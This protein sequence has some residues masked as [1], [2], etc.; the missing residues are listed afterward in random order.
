MDARAR[1]ERD[2]DL[3]AF[4][5]L[6]T[7]DF[8]LIN[9]RGELLDKNARMAQVAKGQHPR[10][11]AVSAGERIRMYGDTA[12]RTRLATR[13]DAEVRITTVWVKQDGQWKAASTQV[14]PTRG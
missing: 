4:A 11:E 14:T 1:S 3:E 7:D 8:V 13:Q 2:R 5:R 12:I 9:V 6:T 10:I